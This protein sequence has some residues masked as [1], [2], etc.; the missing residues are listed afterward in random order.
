MNSRVKEI[1]RKS[2]AACLLAM[3]M[4]VA[5]FPVDVFATHGFDSQSFRISVDGLSFEVWGYGSG[6]IIL[7]PSIRLRDIAYILNGTSAQFNIITS[8]CDSWDFWIQRGS[9]YL[10]TFTELQP[11]S[12]WRRALF[13]SYGFLPGENSPGFGRTAFQDIV[14][15]LD[16]E[17]YPSFS[18]SI[19]A[20]RDIDDIYFSLYDLSYWLG[21]SVEWARETGV[22]EWVAISTVPPTVPTPSRHIRRE[23]FP[24][25][26]QQ[27]IDY[28][29]ALRVRTGAGNHYDTLTFVNR[30]DGFEILDY[31][32]RFV[33]I[34]TA[35]GRGW[36]FAGFL[37]RNRT[38]TEPIFVQSACPD[39]II[40]LWTFEKLTESNQ[41]NGVETEVPFLYAD[42]LTPTLN[43]FPDKSL[44][45]VIYG[46]L[47]GDLIQITQGEFLIINQTAFA[48]GEEWSPDSNRWLQYFPESRFLRYS[49]YNHY[50][51]MYIHYYFIR[52]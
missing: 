21:F 1:T 40:G 28:A 27:L 38:V 14:I 35:H 29:Y 48:A 24:V 12:E 46:A 15:G 11:I 26:S 47:E 49:F 25:G 37:S 9:P 31:C 36:I 2:I 20:V 45:V 5:F 43:V 22:G 41:M 30:G 51:D 39:G 44:R 17:D 8:P 10:V 13:G 23:T 18:I 6:E 50:S 7:D 19:T 34:E 4:V 33:Q 3:M 52:F 42:W 32:G 16:G